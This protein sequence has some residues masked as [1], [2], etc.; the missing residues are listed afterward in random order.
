MAAWASLGA[1]LEMWWQ[2]TAAYGADLA[3]WGHV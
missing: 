2:Q 3:I 1:A